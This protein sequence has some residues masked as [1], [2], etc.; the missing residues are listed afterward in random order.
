MAISADVKSQL[1]RQ[2][3]SNGGGE[4]LI[5]LPL[6]SDDALHSSSSSGASSPTASTTAV[7]KAAVKLQLQRHEPFAQQLPALEQLKFAQA[8]PTCVGMKPE[9]LALE[10]PLDFNGCFL[11][12]EPGAAAPHWSFGAADFAL[13]QTL[14]MALAASECEAGAAPQPQL[15]LSDEDMDLIMD[16]V[17]CTSSAPAFS[18]VC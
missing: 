3:S 14:L 4:K 12:L 18:F 2:S 8:S 10:D 17:V 15:S 1:F 13:D 9:Q 11:E 16:S 6:E 7:G 5:R